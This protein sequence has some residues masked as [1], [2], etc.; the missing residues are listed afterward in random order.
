MHLMSED[1][2]RRLKERWDKCVE[3]INDPKMVDVEITLSMLLLNKLDELVT[4]FSCQGHPTPQKPRAVG[5]MMFGVRD[6][7]A[8]YRF[9]ELLKE[10]LETEKQAVS[11]VLQY[12]K[13]ITLR[14]TPNQPWYPVWIVRWQ[15]LHE[16]AAETWLKV[17]N[18]AVQVAAEFKGEGHVSN[19]AG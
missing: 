11:L 18:A 12:K 19:Q 2:F 3:R 4:I 14:G 10:T 5:S 9:Y 17:N 7:K 6:P 16:T 1:A 13:D 15:I 8:V